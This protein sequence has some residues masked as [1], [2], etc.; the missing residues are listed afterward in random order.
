MV[1]A[2]I[3]FIAALTLPHVSGFNKANTLFTATRTRQLVD[4]VAR[5]RARALVNRSTV[6]ACGFF[7]GVLEFD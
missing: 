6:Y 1:L 5:A 4:D 7:A 3:G 2:I